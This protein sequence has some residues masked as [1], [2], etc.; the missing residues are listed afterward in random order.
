MSTL[1]PRLK[2]IRR[3]AGLSQ[4]RMA[5]ELGLRLSDIAGVETGLRTFVSAKYVS[6]FAVVCQADDHEAE[7]LALYRAGGGS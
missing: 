3:E 2:E 1:G 6:D 5:A 4:A 7:L